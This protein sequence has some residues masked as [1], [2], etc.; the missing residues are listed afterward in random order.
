MMERVTIFN[1][2]ADNLN[3]NKEHLKYH[4]E[5]RKMDLTFILLRFLLWPSLIK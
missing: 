5:L 2:V 1:I 4:S 3:D